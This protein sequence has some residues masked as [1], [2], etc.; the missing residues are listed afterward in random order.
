MGK[1][2]NNIL[3]ADDIETGMFITIHTGPIRDIRTISQD[4]SIS[5][6]QVRDQSMEGSVL[7]VKSINLPFIIVEKNEKKY[8]CNKIEKE[9]IIIDIRENK[10]MRLKDSYVQSLCPEYFEK[11][12]K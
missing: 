3:Q 10:L 12:N 11:R 5:L 1:T 4:N 7:K 8:K 2:T 6:A 9:I